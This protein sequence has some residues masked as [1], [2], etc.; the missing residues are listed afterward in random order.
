[1][2][3]RGGKRLLVAARRWKSARLGLE[4]LRALQ[5]AREVDDGTDAL[6]IALG[7][8]SDPAPKFAAAQGIALW[9]AAEPALTLRRKRLRLPGGNAASASPLR[10][11]GLVERRCQKVPIRETSAPP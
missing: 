5:A 4:P 11:P 9:Q 6:C 8:P 2:L 1:M 7:E 10:G 3:E